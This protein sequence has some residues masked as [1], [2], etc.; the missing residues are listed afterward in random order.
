MNLV[1]SGG[2]MPKTMTDRLVAALNA[3]PAGTTDLDR[4]RTAVYLTVSS[5]EGAIQK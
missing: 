5:P 2:S 1:L 3:L 4:V